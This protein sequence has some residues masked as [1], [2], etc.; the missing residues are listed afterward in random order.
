MWN[1]LIYLGAI[2]LARFTVC[3]IQDQGMMS[4]ND[5]V[6]NNVLLNEYRDIIRQYDDTKKPTVYHFA[7][8]ALCKHPTG[9]IQFFKALEHHLT[10]VPDRLKIQF[11]LDLCDK[12]D[13]TLDE[14]VKEIFDTDG[15]GY[16][17]KDERRNL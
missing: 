1:S 11:I 13:G 16:I 5:D 14:W 8:H 17:S 2:V 15:D 6:N 4:V 9:K 7:T 3:A 12:R 10:D